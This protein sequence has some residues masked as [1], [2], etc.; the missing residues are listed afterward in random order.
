MQ[1]QSVTE[2]RCLLSLGSSAC[3]PRPPLPLALLI[4]VNPNHGLQNCESVIKA[5]LP[6]REAYRFLCWVSWNTS[7]SSYDMV[8]LYTR[9]FALIHILKS[10]LLLHWKNSTVNTSK[11]EITCKA[12]F[13]FGKWNILMLQVS[14]LRA[15]CHLNLDDK[16][17]DLA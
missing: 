6:L 7:R 10:G 8:H 15:M 16:F 14:Y 13:S 17:C 3:C 1:E 11:L 2:N 9:F 5:S 4:Q 12:H